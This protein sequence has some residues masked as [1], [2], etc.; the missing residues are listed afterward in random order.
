M[1]PLKTRR[2]RDA[3]V[4]MA[5]REETRGGM[6]S[7]CPRVPVARGIFASWPVSRVLSGG[8][9]LRDGHSSGTHIAARLEQ[10][11]RVA[12]LETGLTSHVA[13]HARP[14]LFGLAPGGV[15]RAEAV[16]RPAGELLPH[17]FTL[18]ATALRRP[19][20]FVFCGTVPTRFRAVGVTHHRALRSPDFPPRHDPAAMLPS[21]PTPER[22]S[23][24]STP[25]SS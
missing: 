2:R 18:T 17:R 9:L 11:T 21:R 25:R 8:S 23:D 13:A 7:D 6:T 3:Q 16:T 1:T 19:R 22:S 20:R 4:V 14:P 24:P 10:P 15:Y 5:M 12:G